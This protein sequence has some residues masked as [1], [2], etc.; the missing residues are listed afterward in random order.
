MKVWYYEKGVSKVFR[1]GVFQGLGSGSM[2]REP[3][4]VVSVTRG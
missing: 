4:T 2:P 1:A 3:R